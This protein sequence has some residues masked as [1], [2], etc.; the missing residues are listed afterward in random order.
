MDQ[1]LEFLTYLA[2]NTNKSLRTLIQATEKQKIQLVLF[3]Q[4]V[5]Y[6][7]DPALQSRP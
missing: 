5:S 1:P 3:S 2:D 4:P 7:L 6:P